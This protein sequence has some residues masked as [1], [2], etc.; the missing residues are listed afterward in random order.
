M[1]GELTGRTPTADVRR[2]LADGERGAAAAAGLA[3]DGALKN[4]SRVLL[5]FADAEVDLDVSPTRSR[6][7]SGLAVLH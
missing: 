1:R 5:A 3:D 6:A 2:L 7:D 4:L